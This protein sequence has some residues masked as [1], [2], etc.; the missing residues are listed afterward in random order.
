MI[1]AKIMLHTVCYY[2]VNLSP[3]AQPE[4]GWALQYG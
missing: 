4:T 2:F 1:D 3:R